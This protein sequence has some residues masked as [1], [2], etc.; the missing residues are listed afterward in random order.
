M[1]K[2][3][4]PPPET[5]IKCNCRTTAGLIS[6]SPE[7]PKI[8]WGGLGCFFYRPQG[9]QLP[10]AR[11]IPAAAWKTSC[12]LTPPPIVPAKAELS[13]KKNKGSYKK[14]ENLGLQHQNQ[15]FASIPPRKL[16]FH[17]SR[18]AAM[19]LNVSQKSQ[20]RV[21]YLLVF[22]KTQGITKFIFAL[23]SALQNFQ[24]LLR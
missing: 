4:V 14:L 22:E 1:I 2:L 15:F 8:A 12:W 11:K 16:S 20:H 17:K 23:C 19:G 13:S 6:W 21:F 3:A 5:S 7:L 24:F 10:A 18:G 9:L